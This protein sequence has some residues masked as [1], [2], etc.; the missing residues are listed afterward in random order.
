VLIG[1]NEQFISNIQNVRPTLEGTATAVL[2]VVDILQRAQELSVQ[3]AN[4]TVDTDSLNSLALEIDQLLESTVVEANRRINDR[5]IFAGTR[6]TADAF[7]V[8]RV[9]GE[10]TAVTYAG[11]AESIEIEIAEGVRSP[12]N[13]PGD[14]AFQSTVDIFQTLIDLRDSMRA[15]DQDAV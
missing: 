9:G 5:S 2:N 8:T 11:N 6:T 1:K 14:A 7:D 12:I 13:E 10:I 4:E 3:A 15:G